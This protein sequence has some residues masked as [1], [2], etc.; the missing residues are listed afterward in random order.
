MDISLTFLANAFMI[1]G[2]V[3]SLISLFANSKTS[4]LIIYTLL[5]IFNTITSILLF[6]SGQWIVGAL[7]GLFA[8]IWI[9]LVVLIA[10]QGT[11]N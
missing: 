8:L 1:V 7:W 6:L 5:F 4:R 3:L 11:K 9:I 2:G 10:N